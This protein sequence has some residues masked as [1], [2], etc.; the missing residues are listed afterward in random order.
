MKTGT[1]A[2]EKPIKKSGADTGRVLSDS[3][4][5]ECLLRRLSRIEGQFRGIRKMVEEE[6]ECLDVIQQITAVREAISMLGIEL[7][8]DD[9]VCHRTGTDVDEK[10]LKT[11]FRMR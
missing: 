9:L 8:K 7:L 11:L 4:S 5:R 1:Q 6:R 2:K 10:F 3:K